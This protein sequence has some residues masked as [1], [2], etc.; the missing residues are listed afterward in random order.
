MCKCFLKQLIFINC[1]TAWCTCWLMIGVHGGPS[2]QI[3]SLKCMFYQAKANVFIFNEVFHECQ[4]ICN[5]RVKR[6]YK[7]RNEQSGKH[8]HNYSFIAKHFYCLLDDIRAAWIVKANSCTISSQQI[9][10]SIN[11]LHQ[12]C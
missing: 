6:Q 4:F 7:S 3:L 5:T 1:F 2:Y 9:A 11:I 12:Y 8:E 10:L